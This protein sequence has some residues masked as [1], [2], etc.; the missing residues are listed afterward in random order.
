MPREIVNISVGQCGNQIGHVFWKRILSEHNI[1]N[2]GYF[3]MSDDLQYEDLFKLDKIEVYFDEASEDK[4]VPR[5][6]LIDLEPGVIEKV[7]NS[8]IGALFKPDHILTRASGAGNNW[9][10]G[11]YTIGGEV[12]DETMDIIRLN[13]EC[14]D[15]LQGFQ[16]SH[17]IGL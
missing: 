4:Y 12:I 9:A 1:K 15:Q 7:L 16:L 3:D 8:E 13:V 6:V 2:D 17:S 11:H 5:S 14:C 10:K